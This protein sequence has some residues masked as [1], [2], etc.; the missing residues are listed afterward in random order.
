M[1]CSM[2]IHWK[3]IR[4]YMEMSINGIISLNNKTIQGI[5]T[6]VL[7]LLLFKM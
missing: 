6:S 5:D 7:S 1:N 4:K 2:E 3:S